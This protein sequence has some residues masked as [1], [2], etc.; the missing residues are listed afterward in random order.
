MNTQRTNEDAGEPGGKLFVAE[1][2]ATD[3][4]HVDGDELSRF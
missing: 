2:S 4:G 3:G 1:F